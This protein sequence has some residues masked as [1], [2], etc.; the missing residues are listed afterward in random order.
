MNQATIQNV[1]IDQENQRLYIYCVQDNSH[2]TSYPPPLPTYYREVYS[3][4]AL[5]F[6][7]KQ[8]AKVERA[9][10]KITYDK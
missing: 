7:E 6:V 3:F 8:Y 5:R 2:L 9:F 10:E 4:D 1:E